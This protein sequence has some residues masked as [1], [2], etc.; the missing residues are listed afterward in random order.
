[1]LQASG[2]TVLADAETDTCREGQNN[3][4]IHDGYT[5]SCSRTAATAVQ[6]PGQASVEGAAHAVDDGAPGPGMDRR[7]VHAG[8][9]GSR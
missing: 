3:W 7:V 4:K 2:G 9:G 1:M 8:A 6:L 5:L